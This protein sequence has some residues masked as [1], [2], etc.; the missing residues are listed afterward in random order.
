MTGG[1][2]G[3]PDLHCRTLSFLTSW[4]L[5]LVT[6]LI[7]RP[8]LLAV[9]QGGEWPLRNIRTFFHEFE[10][11][12]YQTSGIR[13]LTERAEAKASRLPVRDVCGRPRK[14]DRQ[15]FPSCTASAPE[16][17]DPAR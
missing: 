9:M 6:L 4:W 13:V 15:L 3:L 11:D 14:R 5:K 10:L 16:D 2:R 7:A 8:P 12:H 1:Q 17:I